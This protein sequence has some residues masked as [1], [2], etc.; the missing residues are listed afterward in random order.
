MEVFYEY[1]AARRLG[2]KTELL[3]NY[4]FLNAWV[5][6]F[7]WAF[8]HHCGMTKKFNAAPQNRQK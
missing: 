5:S 2:K 4:K 6:F 7:I 8:K 3:I 1:I